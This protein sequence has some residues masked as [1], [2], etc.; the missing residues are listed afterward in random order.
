MQVDHAIKSSTGQLAHNYLLLQRYRIIGVVGRG[1]FGAVYK[2]L[3]TRAAGQLVAVKEMSKEGLS[4]Q[5]IAEVTG[6]FKREPL[7]LSGLPHPNL[8]P[9][10]D[11]F[12]DNGRWYIIMD[13]IDG[14]T[15]Q[16]LLLN[17][18]VRSFRV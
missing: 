6:T 14:E 1:G 11:H 3:D 18:T 12:V 15:L 13:F 7:I 2:A 17:A 9:I 10:S 8:P 16:Q 4:P 5:Q